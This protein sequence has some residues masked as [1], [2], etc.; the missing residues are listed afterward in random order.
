VYAAGLTGRGRKDDA[1][2]QARM[3][4]VFLGGRFPAYDVYT[5]RT[6]PETGYRSHR[7]TEP[8]G[9][10][11]EI[12][13]RVVGMG[14]LASRGFRHD[15]GRWAYNFKTGTRTRARF[16]FPFLYYRKATSL[17]GS[18]YAGAWVV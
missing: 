4:A 8:L 3:A 14:Y 13:V 16:R 18:A 6:V 7:L 17:Q 11:L 1:K 9:T 12:L 2:Q 10:H 15:R 5:R